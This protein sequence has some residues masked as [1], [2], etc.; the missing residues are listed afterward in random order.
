MFKTPE[1]DFISIL[2]TE[3]PVL[4]DDQKLKDHDADGLHDLGTIYLK[5]KYDDEDHYRRVFFHE[6]IHALCE[7]LGLQLN[8][9]T[10]ECLAH[11]I[12]TMYVSFPV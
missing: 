7:E 8:I 10:E 9:N 6:C 11:R 3:V 12:S 4:I 2:G 1:R 5:S